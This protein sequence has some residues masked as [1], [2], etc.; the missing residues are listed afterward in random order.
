MEKAH[1]RA[2][3]AD[4]SEIHLLEIGTTRGGREIRQ[5]RDTEGDTEGGDDVRDTHNGKK[6]A[7]VV[8]QALTEKFVFR[9][10]AP[11]T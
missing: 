6:M 11:F 9:R 5:G 4:G 10:T 8:V 1:L 7:H 2:G 3:E